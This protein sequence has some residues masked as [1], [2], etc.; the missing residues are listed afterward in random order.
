MDE[1]DDPRD[2]VQVIILDGKGY[3]WNA[4]GE[5]V[6]RAYCIQFRPVI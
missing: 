5:I 2:P 4:D 6:M 3:V 1:E